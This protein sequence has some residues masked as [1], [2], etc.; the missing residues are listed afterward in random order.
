MPQ[1]HSSFLRQCR[2]TV[3]LRT[4]YQY[5]TSRTHPVTIPLRNRL[6]YA[7]REAPSAPP[8]GEL[9]SEREAEGVS[10][11]EWYPFRFC[12]MPCRGRLAVD[13]KLPQ[14]SR[15]LRGCSFRNC[16]SWLP[17]GGSWIFCQSALRNRLAKKTDEGRR[18]V[19][20]EMQLGEWNMF[21]FSP[22]NG[23]I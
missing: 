5:V 4:L 8:L 12:T 22:F 7:R 16:L 1:R 23:E 14:L 19:G 6:V 17:P 3:T 18:T 10:L 15:P 13:P 20:Q 11:V 2:R 21:R 9:L